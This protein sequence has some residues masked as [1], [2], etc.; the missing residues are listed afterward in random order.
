MEQTVLIK[1]NQAQPAETTKRVICG[2]LDPIEFAVKNLHLRESGEVAVRCESKDLA[3]KL[4]K[5]ATES[6]SEDYTI[7][8]QQPLRPR[9]KIIGFSSDMD[10]EKLL[11]CLKKQNQAASFLDLK[12]IRIV[13]SE[14]R[15]SNQMSVI[16]E[17]NAYGFDVLMKLQRVNLG[18][19]RCR[20][21]EA[22]D[23]MRCFNCS[24]YGHK[25]VS[26][27]KPACCPKCSGD[28]KIEEC[29]EQREKCINCHIENSKRQARYE[30]LLDTT[31]SSW[32]S[33]C[34]IFVKR[35]NRARQRIDFSN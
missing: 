30:E 3:L 2:K 22:T 18:W 35:L 6:F 8:I 19:E 34:P 32:S 17:T 23:V 29:E 33:E 24:E 25:A 15:K 10:E 26:C 13:R 7:S 5:T 20:V 4:V 16:L 9:L 27:S 21:I 31:H 14:K 28:H 1:P 11:S 12:V